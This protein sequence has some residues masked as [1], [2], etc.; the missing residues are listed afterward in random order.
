MV[1]SC[2]QRG[3]MK[4]RRCSRDSFCRIYPGQDNAERGPLARHC[5]FVRLSVRE[6]SAR[7]LATATNVVAQNI[8]LCPQLYFTFTFTR[9]MD[10]IDCHISTLSIMYYNFKYSNNKQ[11]SANH[12]ERPAAGEKK[13]ME[14][15]QPFPH[16]PPVDCRRRV[17]PPAPLLP[18]PPLC[19]PGDAPSTPP[20]APGG[21]VMVPAPSSTSYPSANSF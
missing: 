21:G 6:K 19:L 16:P 17:P 3:L 20:L 5:D 4:Q 7:K 10:L 14:N 13:C 11:C 12:R 8:C 2:W 9:C 18:P 1:S 15:T